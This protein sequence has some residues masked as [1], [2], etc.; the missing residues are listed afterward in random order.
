M[1]SGTLPSPDVTNVKNSNDPKLGA[2]FFID[3]TYG[4]VIYYSQIGTGACPKIGGLTYYNKTAYSSGETCM[5]QL[6]P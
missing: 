5:G 4:P 1:G 3:A 2:L 6:A